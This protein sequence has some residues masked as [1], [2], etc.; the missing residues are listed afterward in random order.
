MEAGKEGK[1]FEDSGQRYL[2]RESFRNFTIEVAIKV[3][4]ADSLAAQQI[5]SILR[6]CKI[7]VE[8]M[9]CDR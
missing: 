2:T 9:D 1:E 8:N 7:K 6:S 5:V 4:K 3:S